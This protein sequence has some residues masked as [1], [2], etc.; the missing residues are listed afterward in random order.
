MSL[1]GFEPAIFSSW[2]GCDDQVPKSQINTKYF[3]QIFRQKYL[4]NHNIGPCFVNRF[5]F[6]PLY[7]D[8]LVKGFYRALSARR[9]WRRTD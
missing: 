4:K 6:V 9:R 7:V 2:R 3:R 1:R 8:D 5:Y